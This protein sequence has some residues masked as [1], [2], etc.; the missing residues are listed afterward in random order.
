MALG[1]GSLADQ[2]RA[3]EEH[4][5]KV[6]AAVE[7][8]MASKGFDYGADNFALGLGGVLWS[9]T[10]P[11]S[12]EDDATAY[13]AQH[14]YGIMEEL[15]RLDTASSAT[16][17][18]RVTKEYALTLY[19]A[20][21]CLQAARAGVDAAVGGSWLMDH[22]GNDLQDME[23]KIKADP[24]YAAAEKTWRA[25]A[26]RQGFAFK[27]HGAV[28]TFIRGAIA[29][30]IDRDEGQREDALHEAE[31]L[32][33]SV[34]VSLVPCDFGL[35]QDRQAIR[36]RYETEFVSGHA[37]LLAELRSLSAMQASTR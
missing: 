14:A 11:F 8:C 7:T 37:Q 5:R 26:S 32:E 12:S 34:A 33:R 1:V 13:A 10:P 35:L 6:R 31:T 9:R 30:A 28:M 2:Q 17:P 15:V 27:T 18:A 3:F 25:C 16:D 20:N 19:G 24:D 22:I 36:T 29:K 23:R 21:G 4:E